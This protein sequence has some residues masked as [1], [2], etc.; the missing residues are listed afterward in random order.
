MEI[1]A[2]V[3]REQEGPFEIESLTLEDPRQKEVLVRI[4]GTGI[5]HTDLTVRDG[6]YPPDPPVVL[7]HEGAGIVESVGNRVA[8]VEPGDRV[9]L[10]F[11]YD[12]TCPNCRQG[13]VA[14]CESFFEQNFGGT[15][16]EDDSSPISDNGDPI[17]ANFFGQSS[18]ATHAIAHEENVI[19]VTDDLPL[20]LA[21]PLGCGVQTGAGA[22]MNSLT[23]TPGSSLVVFGTGTVGLSAIM[24]GQVVGAKDIIAVDLVDSRLELASDLGATMTVNPQSVADVVETVRKATDNGADYAVESTGVTDVLRQAFD[25]LAKLGTVGVPGAPPLGTEVSLDVNSFVT[26]GRSVRGVTEGDSYPKEF[27][28]TLIDLYQ[29]GRFPFDEFVEYYEFEDI[30]NAIEDAENGETIKPILRM[31]DA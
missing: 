7:G 3:V 8:A 14:Y 22:V 17:N 15:R 27:I 25:S 29:Q 18:F 9:A 11:N 19:P 4:V 13:D 10:T 12:G 23:V 31:S 5:C 2:A 6:N 24:A 26:T 16:F 20:E 21:G 30:D 28:P 1:E